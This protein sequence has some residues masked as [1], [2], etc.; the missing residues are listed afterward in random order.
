[1]IQAVQT[2]WRASDPSLLTPAAAVRSPFALSSLGVRLYH[3][4]LP[5]R[6][7]V[8]RYV[9]RSPAFVR[10]TWRANDDFG[11]DVMCAYMYLGILRSQPHSCFREQS[12]QNAHLEVQCAERL[13]EGT[14]GSVSNQ[15]RTIA[16]EVHVLRCDRSIQVH[17]SAFVPASCCSWIGKLLGIAARTLTICI[18]SK[19]KPLRR[20][21][22]FVRAR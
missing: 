20:S 17:L 18:A 22:R 1:M 6:R 13:L 21:P 5:T 15:E 12:S 3:L 2:A 10:A 11:E 4:M 7:C 14:R 19:T 8:A 16:R 9:Q